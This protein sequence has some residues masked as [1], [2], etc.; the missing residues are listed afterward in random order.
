MFDRYYD[1][2][3][4]GDRR[5]FRG[6]TVTESHVVGFAGI[7]GDNYVLHMDDEYA[8][9]T[10]F[11]QRVA[12]GLLVLS[13]GAGL[14]PLEA[15]RVVAFLGMS[16]VRFLAPTFLGDTVHPTME[17]LATKDRGPGGLV[18]IREEIINQR[19]ECVISATLSV[20]VARRP[21]S[22]DATPSVADA[23]L[24]GRG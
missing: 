7:T 4:V 13:M 8:R 5:E 14:I 22:A 10:Q 1:E 16:E 2:L 9:T 21:G 3:S 18:S 19:G 17:V 24:P 12:H 6:V 11:G 20:L 15:G 23:A